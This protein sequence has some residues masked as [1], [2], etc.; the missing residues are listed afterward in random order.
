[1][2]CAHG[3]GLQKQPPVVPETHSSPSA[4]RPSHAGAVASPQATSSGAQVHGPAALGRQYCSGPHDPAQRGAAAEPQAGCAATH[5]Q[6]PAT[7]AQAYPVSQAPP[8]AGAVDRSHGTW[9]GS[10]VQ[11]GPDVPA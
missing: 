10:H 11:S 3:A 5:R 1:V 7:S 9:S 8:H 6:V 4:Q 2:L